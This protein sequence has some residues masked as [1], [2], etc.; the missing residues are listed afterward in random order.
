VAEP[1]AEALTMA[2]RR[3][4]LAGDRVQ[5]L[6]ADPAAIASSAAAWRLRTVS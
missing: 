2:G 4:R 5:R 6:A 1:V 3:Y